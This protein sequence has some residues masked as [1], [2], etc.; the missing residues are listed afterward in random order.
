MFKTAVLVSCGTLE[1]LSA[2]KLFG[3]LTISEL[4]GG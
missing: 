2:E 4:R 1:E 3:I